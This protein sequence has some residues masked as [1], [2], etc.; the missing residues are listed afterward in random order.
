MEVTLFF[1]TPFESW[2]MTNAHVLWICPT[3]VLMGSQNAMCEGGGKE[4]QTPLWHLSPLFRHTLDCLSALHLQCT[5]LKIELLR[6]LRW[7]QKSIEASSGATGL[8]RLHTG[9]T[10]PGIESSY[11]FSAGHTYVCSPLCLILSRKDSWSRLSARCWVYFTLIA[12]KQEL[13]VL[14]WEGNCQNK[15]PLRK[16]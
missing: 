6:I 5:R 10:G 12:K 8:H 1:S 13:S 3:S 14:G 2:W 4:C 11:T 9:D 7:W 16:P 15:G